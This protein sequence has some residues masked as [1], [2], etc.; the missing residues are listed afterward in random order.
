[1]TITIWVID[2]CAIIMT[3]TISRSYFTVCLGAVAV[4]VIYINQTRIKIRMTLTFQEGVA[5]IC[6][7]TTSVRVNAADE[8]D[9]LVVSSMKKKE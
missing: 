2:F 6:E 7:S 1:M 3:V 5:L 9:C 4:L 8:R